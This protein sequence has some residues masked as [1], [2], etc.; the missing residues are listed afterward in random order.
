MNYIVAEIDCGEEE[1][2]F[3]CQYFDVHR[4]PKFVLLRPETENWFFKMP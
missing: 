3:M 1:G 4:L 2:L